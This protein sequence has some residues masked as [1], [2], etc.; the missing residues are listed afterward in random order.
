MKIKFYIATALITFLTLF[1]T[2]AQ[3]PMGLYFMETIP[4]SSQINPAMQPRANGFFAL[5]SANVLF[6]SDLAFKDV[7]QEAG[8]DWVTP[9]SERFNYDDLYSAS[10]KAANI[11]LYGDLDIVGAGFRSG[12][13]YFTFTLS[14]KNVMQAGIPSDLFKITELGF[15]DGERFDFSAMSIKEVVYHELALGYSRQWDDRWTFGA[16][17]KPLFGIA[18]GITDINKFEMRTN[19]TSWDVHVDGTVY[20]S[21]PLDVEESQTPGDFPES[22]EGK[23]LQDDEVSEYYSSLNNG[24]LAFDFGAVYEH[25]QEWTFSAAL[26]N[27]GW[28]KFK[29]ELNSLSFNGVYQ[30]DGVSVDG[31]DE[32]AIRKAF[33]DIGDS[34]KT[35]LEYD[36][37]HEKFSIPLTP[38]WYMG[39]SYEWTPSVSFGFLSRS[40][41]QKQ[42]FRQDF[43]LSANIQPYSFVALNLNYSKRIKGGNGLGTAV[44]I[45]AGPLQMYLAADYIPM[46]YADVSFDEGESFPM[47]HRQKD[48]SFRFGLNLIFGRHG[49]RDE[50]MLSVK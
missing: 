27:L 42:N 17:L 22:I 26:T 41:F 50:P 13:D 43:S 34:I 45:F 23:D 37:A 44:T 29:N 19:R 32:D 20:S 11:N 25:N 46:R 49:F 1:Q 33:E 9:L 16:K 47:M 36:V 28:V 30:F 40:V 12:K 35:V 38:S 15:P 2:V 7:F 8:K 24:G 10:G 31:S 39:A 4:Q 6:Q 3:N 5:P 18:G 14:V 21:A 48:L